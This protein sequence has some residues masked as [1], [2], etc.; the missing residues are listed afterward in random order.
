MKG[1]WVAF[2]INMQGIETIETEGKDLMDS[3]EKAVEYF[4]NKNFNFDCVMSYEEY[5]KLFNEEY[6]DW[7]TG[8]H[9][10]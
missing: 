5:L 6:F 8:S 4:V 9:S 7:N 3:H 1:V 2:G 10:R